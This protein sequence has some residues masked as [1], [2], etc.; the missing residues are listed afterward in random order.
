VTDDA[1]ILYL[2]E[3][4]FAFLCEYADQSNGGLLILDSGDVNGVYVV[5][6]KSYLSHYDY[7][8]LMIRLNSLTGGI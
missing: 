7:N 2:D 8:D 6:F 5:R 4:A 1:H 3:N